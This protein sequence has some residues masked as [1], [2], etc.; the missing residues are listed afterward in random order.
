MCEALRELMQDDIAKE[1]ADE[2]FEKAVSLN[3]LLL[4]LCLKVRRKAYG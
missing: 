2:R 4:F 1:R 3:D